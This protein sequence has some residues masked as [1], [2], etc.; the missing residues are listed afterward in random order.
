MQMMEDRCLAELR[1]QEQISPMLGAWGC[2]NRGDL[3]R[4]EATHASSAHA[5]DDGAA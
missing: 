4:P 3:C 1:R 2:K 5:R